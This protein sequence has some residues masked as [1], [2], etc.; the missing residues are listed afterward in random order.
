MQTSDDL[1]E[2]TIWEVTT[3][4]QDAL[5]SEDLTLDD[6]LLE[7]CAKISESKLSKISLKD[8]TIENLEKFSEIVSKLIL[9]ST[10]CIQDPFEKS[11]QIEKVMMKLFNQKSAEIKKHEQFLVDLSCFI[12]LLSG[13]L[14]VKEV[15]DNL[16][17]S[18][19]FETSINEYLRYNLFV[20]NVILKLSCHIKKNR[21]EEPKKVNVDVEIED[22]IEYSDLR[23]QIDEEYTD[24]Y[25]DMDENLLKVWPDEI[26]DR[27]LGVAVAESV[28]NI[29]V[30]KSTNVSILLIQLEYQKED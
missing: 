12:E 4:W 6:Y 16:H 1:S 10:E 24:D 21:G 29:L 27:F 25:C 17:D 8:L 3:S 20:L 5:S 9:C 28:S 2:D 7:S 11:K 14:I 15:K 26:F 18:Q 22:E 30:M 13:N 19:D 23:A